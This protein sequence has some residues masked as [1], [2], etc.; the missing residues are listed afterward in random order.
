MGASISEVPSQK[1]SRERL[2]EPFDFDDVPRRAAFAEIAGRTVCVGTGNNGM[3][4]YVLVPLR[5]R[6]QSLHPA[7]QGRLEPSYS[8]WCLDLVG[9]GGKAG[10]ERARDRGQGCL[11]VGVPRLRPRLGLEGAE[12][13]KHF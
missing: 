10:R 4:F 1:S 2:R 11:G 6:L 12:V 5:L 7:L 13:G 3:A 8:R 9:V